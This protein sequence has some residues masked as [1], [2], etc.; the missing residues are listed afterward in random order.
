MMTKHANCASDVFGEDYVGIDS[1]QPGMGVQLLGGQLLGLLIEKDSVD[2]P[3][4][5][6]RDI[7]E[8]VCHF[9]GLIY[10][11]RLN[12]TMGKGQNE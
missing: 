9:L 7:F 8:P 10:R 2:G 3:E 5:S 6:S 4:E 12:W 11:R 1:Q